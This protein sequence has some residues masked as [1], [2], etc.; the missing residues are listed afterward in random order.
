MDDDATLTVNCVGQPIHVAAGPNDSFWRLVST[1]TWEP[2]TYAAFRQF[3]DKEH[4]YIDMGSWIGP[5]LLYGS[6]LAKAAYGIEPDPIAFEELKGNLALNGELGANVKLFNICIAASSGDTVFGSRTEGGDSTSSLLFTAGKTVWT[7]KA[8][9]FADFIR[10]NDIR[11][12]NFVKMDIEGGEFIVLPGMLEYLRQNRP[13][14]LLSL[15]PC[16]IYPHFFEDRPGINLAWR[17]ARVFVSFLIT[18]NVLR[19]LRF[20][21]FLYDD[22]GNPLTFRQL[23]R[24][25]RRTLTIVASDAPWHQE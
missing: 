12:C 4:S 18:I 15:H 25:C 13:T 2:Q 21:R 22:N 5:T 9:T 3:I 24:I 23:L 11:D 8:L 7:V 10:Q 16:F 6:R 20:Y 1:G 14:L 17:A 19:R